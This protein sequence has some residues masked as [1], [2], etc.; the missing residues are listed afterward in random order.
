MI[1]TLVVFFSSKLGRVITI[2]IV[3]LSLGTMLTLHHKVVVKRAL[4]EAWAKGVQQERNM[5]LEM[6]RQEREHRLAE[7]KRAEAR[8]ETLEKEASE[9][10]TT[11]ESQEVEL[12][13]VIT[14]DAGSAPPRA[15][16]GR[17][18]VRELNRQGRTRKN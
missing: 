15:H 1:T 6:Q 12:E 10:R 9:L 13:K 17:G 7:R 4:A 18:L 5:W 3:A 14:E 16:L 8:I 11:V 2:A